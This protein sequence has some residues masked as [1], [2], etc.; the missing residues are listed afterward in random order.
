MDAIV[1][2]FVAHYLATPPDKLSVN[3]C[4]TELAKK[5]GCQWS[6]LCKLFAGFLKICLVLAKN[7]CNFRIC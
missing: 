5:Y 1:L 2:G 6:F 3:I 7:Q 4:T